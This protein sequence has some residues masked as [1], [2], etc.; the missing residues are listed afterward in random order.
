M[1]SLHTKWL[2]PALPLCG[3]RKWR[4]WKRKMPIVR[5]ASHVHVM[6]TCLVAITQFF[7][8]A[9]SWPVLLKKIDFPK[10]KK[11]KYQLK[12]KYAISI[13]QFHMMV[14]WRRFS[15]MQKH[16]GSLRTVNASALSIN[17][18]QYL[19]MTIDDYRWLSTFNNIVWNSP[20]AG[21]LTVAGNFS[22]ESRVLMQL[23]QVTL[24]HPWG[25]ILWW[26]RWALRTSHFSCKRFLQMLSAM[27]TFD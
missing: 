9:S 25:L 3:E 18:Y 23:Y 19:S 24:S 7:L 11:L 12:S 6:F 10:T 16:C 26:V 4:P 8:D 5:K 20:D 2:Q 17:Y 14:I 22:S 21:A 27:V 13:G 15:T 1:T